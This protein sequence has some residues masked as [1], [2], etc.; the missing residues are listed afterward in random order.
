MKALNRKPL[1]KLIAV[2]I[3]PGMF[4]FAFSIVVPTLVAVWYSL[5]NW[6]TLTKP[7][8][9][10]LANFAELIHDKLFWSSLWNNLKLALYTLIGQV[11]IGYLVAFLLTLRLIGSRDF[12]RT[13]IERT[14][15]DP[16]CSIS[17][18]SR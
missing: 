9:A 7:Q 5:N 4:L 8:W 10:G 1:G 14:R 2:F 15:R 3:L 11:G 13:A 12:L 6:P 18:C 16:S 17:P